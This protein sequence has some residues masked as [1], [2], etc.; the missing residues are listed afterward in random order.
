[1]RHSIRLEL[2]ISFESKWHSG[3]GEGSMISDRLIRTDSRQRP[4]IPGSTLKGVIRESCEK[5]SRTLN[6]PEPS[7]PHQRDLT[8]QDTFMPLKELESPVDRIFGNNYES[9]N[10]FF[11]DARLSDKPPYN[12]LSEQSRICKYRM[13]GT[14]KER[15]LFSTQ[16]A[17]PLTFRT[18]IEGYHDNL[19]QLLDNHPPYEYCVLIAGIKTLERIGGDKST[20]KGKIEIL[21]D[22]IKY[23]GIIQNYDLIG[24]TLFEHLNSRDLYYEL[25]KEEYSKSEENRG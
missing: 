18:T 15:H 23:N 25:F 19:I 1:M 5:L 16:Y 4:Y 24:N 13:L 14:A 12:F 11:R 10:L 2:V 21:I 17:A 22:K 7:D 8:I 3:S 9:G 20:G 6:F